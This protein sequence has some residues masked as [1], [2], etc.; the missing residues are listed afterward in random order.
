MFQDGL[1]AFFQMSKK[2]EGYLPWMYVDKE[3]LVTTGMG[4]LIDP[5]GTALPLPWRHGIG[6]NFASPSDITAAWNTVKHSGKAGS[7]GGNQGGLTDLRLDDDGIQQL[8]NSKI[9]N[10]ES[11]LRARF[12]NYD[13]LN[14]DAQIVLNSMA[15]AMGPNF[16]YPKFQSAINQLVPDYAAAAAQA[17][18]PDNPQHSMDYPAIS[19]PGLRPRNV[20]NQILLK[21][22]AAGL[23]SGSPADQ[24][25]DSM[26]N[27]LSDVDAIKNGALQLALF[28]PIAAARIAR[29]NP[30]LAASGLVSVGAIAVGG[31]ILYL[32]KDKLL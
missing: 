31:S 18:M 16:N 9:A 23:A 27:V 25:Y 20:A 15:W 17:Y 28:N 11:I 5:I 26:D 2:F 6:G 8:I 30:F 4:D 24:L 32:N 14:T 21:N 7:G 13:N 22:A 3:N 29:K 12:P 19:N 1:K 10:N